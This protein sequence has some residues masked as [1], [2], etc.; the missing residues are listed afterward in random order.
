MYFSV[1]VREKV[2]SLSYIFICDSDPTSISDDYVEPGYRDLTVLK[3][4][5]PSISEF[6]GTFIFV[7]GGVRHFC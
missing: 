5:F 3:H 4:A 2:K 6:L 7:L 1:H